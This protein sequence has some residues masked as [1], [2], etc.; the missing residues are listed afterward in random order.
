MKEKILRAADIE[1][2]Q[3]DI[4]SELSEA[5]EYARQCPYPGPEE[6]TAGLYA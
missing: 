1:K 6:M 4:A 5:V 2:I 3:S